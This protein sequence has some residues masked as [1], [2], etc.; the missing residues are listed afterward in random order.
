MA[1][2]SNFLETCTSWELWP[3]GHLMRHIE[4]FIGLLLTHG[5]HVLADVRTILFS[6]RNPPIQSVH[7]VTQEGYDR[8]LFLTLNPVSVVSTHHP[9]P[10]VRS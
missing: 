10:Q 2:K 4:Q 9:N 7:R 6:R 3:L 5:I 1:D 8:L